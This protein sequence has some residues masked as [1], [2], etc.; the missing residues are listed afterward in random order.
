[1]NI[2]MIDAPMGEGK[3]E[4]M[5]SVSQLTNNTATLSSSAMLVTVNI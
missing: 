1:M 2:Q 5:Q 4:L 3:A